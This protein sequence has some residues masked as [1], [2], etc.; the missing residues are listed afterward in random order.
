MWIRSA[1]WIGAPKPGS[2]QAFVDAVTLEIMPALRAMPGVSGARVLWPR[3]IDGEAPAIACQILVEYPGMAQ[4]DEMLASPERR[5]FR[6]RLPEFTA[7]FDGV[8]SH[9]DYEVA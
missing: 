7:L 4:I 5:A 6:G 9:I 2:E 1:F 8:I 3:R